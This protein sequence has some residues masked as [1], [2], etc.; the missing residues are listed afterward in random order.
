VKSRPM[1]DEE[2]RD[3][4]PDAFVVSWCGVDPAKYRP[5]VLYGN[6]AWAELPAIRGRRVFT[7]PEAYLGRPGPRLVDGVKALRRIVTGLSTHSGP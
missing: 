7:V 3:L 1:T 2:V 6:P 5:D 4:A